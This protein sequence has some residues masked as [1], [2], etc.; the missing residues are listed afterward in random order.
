MINKYPFDVMDSLANLGNMIS[1]SRRARQLTQEELAARA[2]I[3]RQ[4]VMAIEKG[5]PEV[6]MGNY[7]A[8][9]WAMDLHQ[10][11]IQAEPEDDMA[12]KMMQAD[13]PKRVRKM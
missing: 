13:L 11:I 10:A 2:G 12:V 9:L 4:T 8:T 3:S 6:A 5:S 7:M 1:T